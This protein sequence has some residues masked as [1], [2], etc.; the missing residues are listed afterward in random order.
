MLQPAQRLS[1]NCIS[2]IFKRYIPAHHVTVAVALDDFVYDSA[3]RFR[4]GGAG[5]DIGVATTSRIA[6]LVSVEC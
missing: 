3:A 1:R 5:L 2:A 6:I 4:R